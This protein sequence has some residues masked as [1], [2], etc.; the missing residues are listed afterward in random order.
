MSDFAKLM[1]AI[2]VAIVMLGSVGVGFVKYT[3]QFAKAEDVVQVQQMQIDTIHLIQKVNTRIDF[4][5]LYERKRELERE[6]PD[7]NE[8]PQTVKDELAFIEMQI[9]LL[10]QESK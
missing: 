3:D 10:K 1:W 2:A 5:S 8:R 6:H 9:E 7:E 4:M